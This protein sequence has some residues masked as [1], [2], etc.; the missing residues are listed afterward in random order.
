MPGVLRFGGHTVEQTAL[1]GTGT[2]LLAAWVLATGCSMVHIAEPGPDWTVEEAKATIREFEIWKLE[3][4][5]RFNPSGP[6]P[7]PEAIEVTDE[8][9]TDVEIVDTRGVLLK[10]YKAGLRRIPFDSI[11]HATVL[12]GE[13]PSLIV[14]VML[15]TVGILSPAP[16]KGVGVVPEYPQTFEFREHRAQKTGE[17][18]SLARYGSPLSFV[19]E[20]RDSFYQWKADGGWK[21]FFPFYLFHLS[22]SSH[23]SDSARVAEAITF[24]ARRARAD[25]KGGR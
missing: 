23:D 21:V 10:E 9:F 5:E 7:E 22:L 3:Q 25:A 19:R 12:R 15:L 13:H 11:S 16:V 6:R 2:A 24:L 4:L 20:D 17:H 8:H 14:G 18:L 1:R